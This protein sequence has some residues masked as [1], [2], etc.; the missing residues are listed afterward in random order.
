[1]QDRKN[2][3]LVILAALSSTASVAGLVIAGKPHQIVPGAS[4][5]VSMWLFPLI[6]VFTSMVTEIFGAT[7]A[8][9]VTISTFICT[10][11]AVLYYLLCI[12]LPAPDYWQNQEPYRVVLVTTPRIFVA[13]VVAYLTAAYTGIGTQIAVK[14]LTSGRWLWLQIVIAALASQSV[15]SILFVGV[16]FGGTIP[17]N[18]IVWMVVTSAILKVGMQLAGI[19][20]SYQVVNLVKEKI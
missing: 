15:D 10:V 12:A 19:P 11:V 14:K 16:A 5:P 13:S 20:V 18:A 1:M 3:V 9:W 2:I 7:T 4:I 17:L 8:R 6:F